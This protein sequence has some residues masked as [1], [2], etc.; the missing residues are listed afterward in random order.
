MQCSKQWYAVVQNLSVNEIEKKKVSTMIRV[1]D[2]YKRFT[3]WLPEKLKLGEKTNGGGFY[4][5]MAKNLLIKE[6]LIHGISDITC[7]LA[8]LKE[9]YP[10]PECFLA[11]GS[12]EF[13]GAV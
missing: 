10:D 5:S 8:L 7:A 4:L 3:C 12:S 13:D 11:D 2:D 6:K 1:G 9:P